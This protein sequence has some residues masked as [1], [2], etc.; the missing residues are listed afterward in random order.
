[1]L[2]VWP[3]VSGESREANCPRGIAPNTGRRQPGNCTDRVSGTD[4][5]KERGKR[6]R[7]ESDGVR[8]IFHSLQGTTSSARSGQA[9][10]AQRTLFPQHFGELN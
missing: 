9:I 8:P 10:R 4:E 2:C 7:H 3:R 5:E 1:M 6:I